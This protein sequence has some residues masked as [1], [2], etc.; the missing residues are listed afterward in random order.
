MSF[1]A[2]LVTGGAVT[3]GVVYYYKIDIN[4]TTERLSSDLKQLSDSLVQAKHTATDRPTAVAGEFP[5]PI[6]TRSGV[7]EG[8]KQRWNEILIGGVEAVRTT[9]WTAVAASAYSSAKAALTPAQAPTESAATGA[10]S[11]G[12]QV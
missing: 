10:T 4:K 12:R 6:P 7:K 9:E 2:K 5:A 11:A 1:F 8:V 3:A